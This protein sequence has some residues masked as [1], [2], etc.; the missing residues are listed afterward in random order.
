[1]TKR[2]LSTAAQRRRRRG[3]TALL[4]DLT[5]QQAAEKLNAETIVVIPLGAAAKEHGHHLRLNND[6]VIAESLKQSLAQLDDVVIAPTVNYFYYPAFREYPG[7]ITLSKQTSAALIEE[8]C[9]SLARFGPRRFYVLNTGISSARAL[10]LSAAQLKKRGLALTFTDLEDLVGKAS[11][12]LT[13]QPGGCHADE[14]ETSVMLHLAPYRV[15]MTKAASDFDPRAQGRLS[16]KRGSGLCYSPSG[17]WGDATLADAAKGSR[18]VKF[19]IDGI[20][21]DLEHLRQTTFRKR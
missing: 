4:E 20:L 12:G 5:W 18:V 11:A 8:I 2:H 1:M 19:I 3:E 13:R 21:R 14:I 7:S 16:R 17:V 6:F 10:K 9:L 15:D